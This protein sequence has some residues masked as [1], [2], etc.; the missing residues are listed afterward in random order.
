MKPTAMEFVK[1]AQSWVGLN[2]TDGGHK[3][4]ID[5]YNKN[6]WR[7]CRFKMKYTGEWCAAFV[8]ACAVKTKATGIVPIDCHCN[9]IIDK[10]KKKGIWI[11]DE[12]TA[13]KPGD[14]VLYDWQ[15]KNPKA[16]DKAPADHI[17]IVEKVDHLT[18]T[19]IVIEGNYKQQV[20]RRTLKF[21]AKYLRGFV[22]PKFRIAKTVVKK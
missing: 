12:S 8:T 16:N 20:K 19:F 22:R 14:L 10:A 6:R 17:G 9:H 15:D 4:I 18:K 3:Q 13:P 21:N 2:E 7:G 1:Q 11:E 5:I